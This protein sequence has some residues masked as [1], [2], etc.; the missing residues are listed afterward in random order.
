MAK[1]CDEIA[2]VI[3]QNNCSAINAAT[4]AL[5]IGEVDHQP[6]FAEAVLHTCAHIPLDGPDSIWVLASE[7]EA[8]LLLGDTDSAI[9]FYRSALQKILPQ[10]T[11][12]IQSMYNQ[13]CRL[14][15]ALGPDTV[16]PVIGLFD[17]N[18]RL[19]MVQPGPFGNCVG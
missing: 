14:H 3:L 1:V 13:L 19:A 17:H 7:G 6:K 12:I 9:R 8:A 2:S 10:E 16:Q 11:G 15:W 4:L 5:L 18:G